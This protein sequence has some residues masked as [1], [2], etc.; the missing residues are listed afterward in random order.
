MLTTSF[1]DILPCFCAT[2]TVSL[3]GSKSISNRVLLLAALCEGVTIVHDVLQSEDT[4]VMLESLRALGCLIE[5]LDEQSRS[6]RVHGCSGKFPNTTINLF[7]A[8]AGS[9]LRPLAATLALM[10]GSFSIHGAPRMHERP[11]K[12]LVDALRD[13]GCTISYLGDEGCPPLA[14]G[15]PQLNLD[16]PVRVRGDVSSQFLTALLLTLPLLVD[17]SDIV[18]EV[19]TEMISKPYI[20]ITLNM[21]ARFGVIVHNDNWQKFIIPAGSQLISP[22][23]I[24]IE[25]DASSASYFIALGAIAE[26]SSDGIGI[27][28]EGIGSNSVQGDINFIDAAR[29]MGAHITATPN[30]LHIVRG[31]WPLSAI[32]MDCNAI[33]DAA[34]TLAIMALYANGTTRLTNIASWRVKETDRISAMATELRKLGAFVIEG[35]DFIEITPPATSDDW[36]AATVDTYQ[37]HRMA[38]C[39][40]LA[41]FNPAR[42]VVRIMDPACVAKTFPDYFETFFT[43]TDG[44]NMHNNL[45][46]VICIDGP[47]ASGK[48]T[49]AANLAKILDFHFLDSGALYRAAA[50]A[51]ERANIVIEESNEEVII[52]FVEQLDIEFIDEIRT[53]L[54]GEDVSVAIRN[55][56]VATLA[57]KIASFGGVRSALVRRQHDQRKSPGLVADGRDM[58]TV[59]FPDAT[60]KIFLTASASCRAQRRFEQMKE[61][62]IVVTIEGLLADIK[63][64]DQRDVSRLVAPLVPAKDA[65]LLDNSTQTVDESLS[66][67]LRWWHETVSK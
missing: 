13:I 35:I 28:L 16:Q 27:T 24:S 44:V 37:D 22:S 30:S 55:A 32:T 52:E 29:A 64:R 63:E 4:Q 26:P 39:F 20:A 43:V 3:P 18:I 34:M 53:I 41:A 48:G 23:S 15:Q 2:G 11:I 49:L 51:A 61:R 1:V 10:G 58:G 38:M 9:A 36:S 45:A 66:E 21:L 54:N 12:D 33:P 50:L 60:L 25:K 46:P 14:I 8:N 40:S 31:Q 42:V 5:P 59:I 57:S 65:K 7:L 47:T 19:T 6:L 62:G 17:T 56:D 67:V